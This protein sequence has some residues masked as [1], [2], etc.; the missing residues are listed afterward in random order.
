[1]KE[2]TSIN[3]INEIEKD[4]EDF[5]KWIHDDITWCGNECAHTEC[6]RNTANRLTKGGLYSAAMFRDTEVCPLN[7]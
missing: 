7:K 6:E 5:Y 2:L 4:Y 3:Q 1:M